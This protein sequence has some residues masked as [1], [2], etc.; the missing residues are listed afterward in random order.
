[1][2]FVSHDRY[3]VNRVADHL[4]ILDGG[5]ACVVEGNYEAYQLQ[6]QGKAAEAAQPSQRSLTAKGR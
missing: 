6:L 4:L 1:M 2:L 5:G 3:F